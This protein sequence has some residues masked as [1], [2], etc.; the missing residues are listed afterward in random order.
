MVGLLGGN[1]EEKKEAIGS[2]LAFFGGLLELV[3]N[4]GSFGEWR[5][6]PHT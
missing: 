2:G 5:V 3:V 1:H 4:R 6:F